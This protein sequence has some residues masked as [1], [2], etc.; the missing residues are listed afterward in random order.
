M[1]EDNIN[2]GKYY[3]D[4]FSQMLKKKEFDVDMKQKVKYRYQEPIQMLLKNYISTFTP[5]DNILLYHQTGTG[6]C[7]AINTP[8]LMYDGTIKKVQDIK[9]GDYLMGDDSTPRKVLSLASGTDR[10]YD[11]I[12]E[13]GESYRVNEEHILCLKASGLPSI[14]KND[15]INCRNY[16][17][18]YIENNTFKSKSFSLDKEN[19]AIKFFNTITWEQIIEIS[20]KD[21]L[22][23]SNGRKSILKGYK[24]SVNFEEKKLPIDP[25]ML[26]YWIGDGS[27][28]G[29]VITCQDATIL[30]YFNK[31]LAFYD[32]TLN[33][34]S[35]YSY[36][37]SGSGKIG[38]N[39]FLNTLKDLNLI[40]NKHIPYIYKCNSR[41]NRLK[42][43]AGLLD[44][45]GYL[46]K[47]K[48]G[49]EFSQSIKNEQIIDDIIYL[50][51]SLGFACYKNK[52][53][54]TWTYKGEK[55]IGYAWRIHINGEGIEEIPV[56]CKRKKANARKQIKN[57]LV[58]GIKVQYVHEDNYYGFT[59]DGNCRYLMGDFTVTHNT[60]SAITIAEGF[61]EYITKV[62]R[63]IIVLVKNKNIEKNFINELLSRCT[64]GAYES[65]YDEESMN[66]IRRKINKTYD[67]MT[68]GNFTNRILGKKVYKEDDQGR[69]YAIKK[70]NKVMRV[71]HDDVI[72]NVNNSIIIIDEVH[73][74]TYNDA[75]KALEQVLQKSINY[76]LIL[77][78][79]TP[80]YDNVKE[81]AEISN[82][83]NIKE[84]SR[85]LPIRNNL[86]PKYMSTENKDDLLLKTSITNITDYGLEEIVKAMR[87]KVSYLSA[88]VDTFPQRIDVGEKLF[89]NKEGSK[90]YV[91]CKMSKYQYDIYKKA[92][93]LDQS[94]QDSTVPGSSTMESLIADE[95]I[96]DEEL[97]LDTETSSSI[98]SGLY[99]NS[100]DASTMVYPD[101][102]YGKAGFEKLTTNDPCLILTDN[103]E[104]GLNYYSC[105]LATLLRNI[106][107]NEGSAFVYS[108]YVNYGGVQLIMRI[109]IA[110]G[111]KKYDSRNIN[112]DFDY[113]RFV[114]YD[115]Q[116]TPELRDKLIKVFNS[117]ENKDGK[118]IKVLVGSPIISEGITLKNVRQ[119][120]IVDPYWNMSKINQII[121][122]AIRN[123]SHDYLEKNK[124]NVKIY[125]YISIYDDN[126]LYID[127]EKYKLS[128]YK[129]RSNKK[130]ERVLKQI[131]F[132]CYLNKDRNQA[133]YNN[134][135]NYS[136]E[137][138]YQLCDIQ[139]MYKLPDSVNKEI[140]SSTYN[141]NIKEFEKYA[142]SYVKTQLK[143]LF[144]QYFVWSLNDII[145]KIKELDPTINTEVIY[146]VL[147]AM[148]KNKT[149]LTDMYN[150]K[151]YLILKG[152][153]YIFNP[154]DINVESSIYD[155]L[156]DFTFDVND[157]TYD[158][159]IS[160]KEGEG[161]TKVAKSKGKEKEAKVISTAILPQSKLS[162]ED[163]NFNDQIKDKYKI[164][165]SYR[166]FKTI[167]PEYPDGIMD[168][169][170]RIVDQRGVSDKV[171][172]KRKFLTGQ[173][174]KTMKKNK[175]L[176]ILK[177]IQENEPGI[178]NEI[179][180]FSD[181]ITV[182]NLCVNIELFLE[183]NNR[184]T[185]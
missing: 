74:I 17:I 136:A 63:K 152:D 55:K 68:Y 47:N 158:A 51:R 80:I 9:V 156:F 104:S 174:C 2:E 164:F 141:I 29:P 116:T 26:G 95:N 169:K 182:E 89:K 159:F 176:D 6:K 149:I 71:K 120:H 118:I 1:S 99:K 60:C 124:R 22:K 109:L 172:D 148:V 12:P 88:N 58:T 150:R 62:N 61:K 86:L 23:L 11:V 93:E 103:P 75:Y 24:T 98:S 101:K 123:H 13:K 130:V 137:C 151:G 53:Q 178:N 147:D 18:Q 81:I 38:N 65:L 117:K 105:K 145:L 20:I 183:K 135:Q 44:S 52:K 166:S 143:L 139:C 144:K 115:D 84:P 111:F 8:I 14:R 119:V 5:Y 180:N 70:N 96:I 181:N 92:L 33:Y 36:R 126:I 131:S 132:D 69:R 27:K 59:L 100:N 163:K 32:L 67:I 64:M 76:R 48:A 162:R 49:Y 87:G 185:K 97:E 82:L 108:N 57:A 16:N 127:Q 4:D 133:Y 91:F 157:L 85:L 43:L 110:N 50:C 170:F 167:T 155:K 39:I 21:Y 40:N 177:Y 161:K 78:T 77:L 83:L 138:D 165:G 173:E 112:K 31:N 121:G 168:N 79:A 146:I 41:E 15:R 10:M 114:M 107:N 125:K 142:M 30:H 54:T 7:H 72:E 175:L 128:E 140:D 106:I 34:Q 94:S 25:Y 113:K 171:Q 184:I 19:E 37:I 129:D 160:Q 102:L 90:E 179:L 42:L 45:D 122:R 46:H 35:Q 3:S 154:D 56:L 73:N 134:Y 66:K 153:Y 28:R